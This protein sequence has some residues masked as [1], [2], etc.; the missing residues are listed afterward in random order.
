MSRKSRRA[1][2]KGNKVFKRLKNRTLTEWFSGLARGTATK[3]G[4]I[5]QYRV[6]HEAE[7]FN[8]INHENPR[9]TILE[10]VNAESNVDKLTTFRPP[11]L[12]DN[13]I[14]ITNQRKEPQDGQDGKG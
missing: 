5:P 11:T 9:P 3:P 14:P 7:F 13:D 1:F 10:W 6:D 8:Q 2:A 12:D 4:P